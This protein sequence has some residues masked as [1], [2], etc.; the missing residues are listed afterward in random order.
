MNASD[1][2]DGLIENS[3]TNFDLTPEESDSDNT[4]QA[5][6]VRAIRERDGYTKTCIINE[7]ARRGLTL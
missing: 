4:L 1:F 5:K 6:L 2:L 7:M 3:D